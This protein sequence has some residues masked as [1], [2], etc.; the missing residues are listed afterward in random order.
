MNRGGGLYFFLYG[1]LALDAVRRLLGEQAAERAGKA[2]LVLLCLLILRL[3]IHDYKRE[4]ARRRIKAHVR[5]WE[6][7]EGGV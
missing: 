2:V 1:A 3:W 7:N 4:Q 6:D 5:A